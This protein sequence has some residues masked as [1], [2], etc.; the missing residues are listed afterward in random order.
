[1]ASSHA[2]RLNPSVRPVHIIDLS[3]ALNST[4]KQITWNSIEHLGTQQ[5]GKTKNISDV[6]DQF[7]TQGLSATCPRE[8]LATGL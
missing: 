5:E 4:S 8:A 7:R 3:Y 2:T 6:Q 1:M